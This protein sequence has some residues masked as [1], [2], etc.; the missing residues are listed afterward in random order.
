MGWA[1]GNKSALSLKYRL[2]NCVLFIFFA[3][4]LNLF[5][6]FPFQIL[7]YTNSNKCFSCKMQNFS[8]WK[9]HFLQKWTGDFDPSF[10]TVSIYEPILA[11]YINWIKTYPDF[12][13][14]KLCE[15]VLLGLAK[16]E[17]KILNLMIS[18]AR[19]YIFLSKIRKEH[20]TLAIYKEK[21]KYFNLLEKQDII[22][23]AEVLLHATTCIQVS[24]LIFFLYLLVRALQ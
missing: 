5:K 16:C 3:Y 23:L 11:K 21:V 24:L 14:V 9:M 2:A 13:N 17:T 10:F 19:Y 4:C 12:K 20:P 22:R 15:I 8:N 7:A 6:I 18:I 1:L